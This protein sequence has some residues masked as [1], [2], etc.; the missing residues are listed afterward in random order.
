MFAKITLTVALLLVAGSATVAGQ[1]SKDRVLWDWL[2]LQVQEIDIDELSSHRAIYALLT[3]ARGCHA[4]EQHQLADEYFHRALAVDEKV[5]HHST[6]FRYALDTDQIALA[7]KIAEESESDSLLN[8]WNRERFR[9]GD[10]E[11]IKGYPRGEMT[12][13]AAWGLAKVF[14]ELGDYERA[15]E[16]VSGIEST[17]GNSPEEVAGLI[18]KL[19]AIKYRENGELENAK[20]YI[21]KAMVIAYGRGTGYVGYAIEIAH[22]S[23]HG[24]LTKNLDEFAQKGAYFPGHMGRELIQNLA[25]ELVRTGYDD[26]AKRSVAL[27]RKPED[28]ADSM[29]SI[30]NGQA[31]RGHTAA[32]FKT[33]EEIND[34][35]T[36]DAA[37]IDIAHG[38]CKTG[39]PEAAEELADPVFRRWKEGK[40]S[41]STLGKDLAALYARLRCQPKLEQVIAHAK[42]PESKTDRI[43]HAI[44]G[45]AGSMAD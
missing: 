20:R 30:A 14:V 29:R 36:R 41:D 45:F 1:D 4:M 34:A 19:I 33:V 24:R 17:V 12:F 37:R 11:A 38:L 3:I 16:F 15:G 32:A 40:G 13:Y 27:L 2:M 7:G 44:L 39:Q 10:H 35:Q 5:S 22:R 25:R 28:V 31:R 42:T 18:F 8:S 9:R 23:I 6:L 21:D 26:E 43:L